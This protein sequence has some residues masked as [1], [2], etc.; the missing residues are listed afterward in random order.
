L[1]ETVM[2][3]YS[4]DRR[5][6][7]MGPASRLKDADSYIRQGDRQ[8]EQARGVL[9]GL[10]KE[11]E[12]IAKHTTDHAL[13]DNFTHVQQFAHRLDAIDGDIDKLLKEIEHSLRT[14]K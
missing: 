13:R 10:A 14:F 8:I 12:I 4:Y 2:S 3:A 9:H 1:A 11:L 5:K 7:A 6:L